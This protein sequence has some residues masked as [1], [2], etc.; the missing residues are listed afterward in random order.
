MMSEQDQGYF[1]TLDGEKVHYCKT[2]YERDMFIAELKARLKMTD[3]GKP[4][5]ILP[6]LEEGI[7]AYLKGFRETS[8]KVS[9]DLFE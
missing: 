4:V 5:S 7:K 3:S 9:P 8:R 1:V 6:E 2:T